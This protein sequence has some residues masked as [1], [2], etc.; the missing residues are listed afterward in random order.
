MLAAAATAI[1]GRGR[2]GAVGNGTVEVERSAHKLCLTHTVSFGSLMDQRTEHGYP[3][4][5]R[6][7]SHRMVDLG[8][9]EGE[10]EGG[11]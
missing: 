8:E 3:R 10:G 7:R 5:K 4:S 2:V 11:G 6:A 1:T 9:S